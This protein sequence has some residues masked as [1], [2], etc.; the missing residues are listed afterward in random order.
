MAGVLESRRFT[1]TH[2]QKLSEVLAH[3]RLNK[4]AAIPYGVI[5][6]LSEP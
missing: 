6:R 3:A 2:V 4:D 1:Q 5:V